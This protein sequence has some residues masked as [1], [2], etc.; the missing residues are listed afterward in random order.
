[1]RAEDHLFLLLSGDQPEGGV[2]LD[3]LAMFRLRHSDRSIRP[4][5]EACRANRIV[6][7]ALCSGLTMEEAV[8]ELPEGEI[9][10]PAYLETLVRLSMRS[11]AHLA[12]PG[13]HD[14]GLAE[15]VAAIAQAGWYMAATG[16]RVPSVS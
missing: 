6:A 10:R 11:A 8:A 4:G 16:K 2:R 14:P 7:L 12:L 5:D 15:A 9:T 13:P 1:M 3:D